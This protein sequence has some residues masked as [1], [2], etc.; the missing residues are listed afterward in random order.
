[1]CGIAGVISARAPVDPAQLGRMC[2]SLRHRGPDSLGTHVQGG[3]GLGIRRLAV[4]DLVSGDQPLYSEDG[5]VVLVL[6][7]EIYN[8]EELRRELAGRGHRFATGS[9]AE[10]VVHL[11]EELGP[12][13]V[14]RLRGMF[15]FAVWDER[16]AELFL[17]RDRVGKKPL[18]WAQT[19]DALVFG[20]EP[21]AVLD[22]PGVGRDVDLAAI[23]AFLVNQYV[24][25]GRSAFRALRKLPPASTLRWRPGRGAPV[26]ERWW[27]LEY[28]P[29]RRVTLEDA[30]EELRAQVLDAVRLRLRSDVP[31]G[32]FLSG[33]LDS[34]VVVAAMART[35]AEPVDT[36]TAAFPGTP[37]D[38]S[39]H[40][41][42]VAA[43]YGTRHHELEVGPP[44]PEVLPR[45]AWHFGEPFADPAA[46]PTFQLSELVAGHVTVALNGDGGDESF[47]G[48][49]R[50]RQLV[51]TLAADRAP[52][53]ARAGVARALAAVAGGTAGRA[54]L[55]RAARLAGRLALDP[56][57][58]YA[59]L[60]RFLRDDDRRRLYTPALRGAV[61]GHDPLGH[62]V[63]A[64]E[65]SA[66][67]E[68][69]DRLMATDLETYLADDL[70]AKV[71]VASMAHSV[72]V[73]SPL[74]DTE[75]MGWAARLP[76][77]LKASRHGG[78]RLLRHAALAWLD[79]D[80]V[81]RPKQGFA[82]PVASWLRGPLRESCEDLLL[83]R[84]ARDRGLFVPA[85]VERLLREHREGFDHAEPLW[86]L[87][88]LELWFRTCVDRTAVRA[89][90]VVGV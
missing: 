13:C 42:R 1:M 61:L 30:A 45:L 74:L 28:T 32:A 9:D 39:H 40:A 47:A 71:D 24:P 88:M 80:L 22:H 3:V 34:S 65:A 77:E 69:F 83:D 87:L 38:E 18:F 73:R 31:L 16:S 49:E 68:P 12:R 14:E 58:R 21:R 75:L 27:R 20:S 46:L 70:L 35:A 78:K 4:I 11:W 55:P 89:D 53:R 84:R 86:A 64:W 17:A 44:A 6:N 81:D 54:P 72:E 43:R 76:V 50:Y 60:F 51:L 57:R 59:D 2:E 66:G 15:A 41:R 36:F 82:V 5:R 26:V 79:E 33:G 8:H 7:G 37:V 67:L 23:D 10:V 19:A 90:E 62:V 63:A 52:R 48:Y 29:K 25:H 56:P 85:E